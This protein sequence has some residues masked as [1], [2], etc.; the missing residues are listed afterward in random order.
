M[1]KTIETFPEEHQAKRKVLLDAVDS[2]SDILEEQG[3]KNEANQTLTPETVKAIRDAGLFRLKLAHQ[4]GGAEADPVTQMEV[5]EKL[6]YYDLSSAWCTMVGPTAIAALGTFLPEEGVNQVFKNEHTPTAA[7][8]FYPAG[9]LTPEGDGYRVNG[10]WRFCSGIPHAEWVC[11]SGI[12]QN[13]SNGDGPPEVVF[14]SFPTSEVI[15]YDNWGP[16]MGLQ[17]TGSCDWSV[18]NYYLPKERTFV[19]D[20]M[21]PEP[22]RGGPLYN[23]PPFAFVAN[24]HGSVSLGAARRVLDELAKMATSTRGEFRSSSLDTRPVIH[25]LIG[26]AD[27]K[28]RS[29]RAFLFNRYEELWQKVSG[30]EKASP[31]DVA[32]VRG[33]A[34]YAT[35]VAAEI[36][37]LGFRYGGGGA[38]F[39]PNIFERSLR[40]L[41]AATQHQV[42]SDTAYENHGKFLLGLEADPMA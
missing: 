8:S 6:A 31:Q 22:L 17:G 1:L 37:T 26:E 30:G 12:V 13:G 21:N 29:A 27:L 16:I 23:L 40:D 32:E 5:L 14:V 28:L 11:G 20:L 24:E 18:E 42:M 34:V 35:H 39:Q 10:R 4:W 33:A 9:T 19:W 2:I 41:H 7:I 25:R 38:L 15:I 3:P 36:G